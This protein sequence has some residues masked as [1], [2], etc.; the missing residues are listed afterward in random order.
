MSG[1]S[2]L[3]PARD[4]EATIAEAVASCLAQTLPADEVLVVDDH[5]TD[6]TA[7]V[8]AAAGARVIPS[9]GRGLVAALDT[10]LRAAEGTW[11]ARMDADD[12]ADPRRLELQ[13][14]LLQQR[15][16]VDGGVRFFRDDG[17]VP[18][19]MRRYERFVNTV[20]VD[21]ELLVE[22]F[23]VH[24]AA[25]FHRHAVVEAGGYRDGPFPEDYELW[26]R[27]H[28][29]GWTFHKV[30]EL[31]V[32][33]RDRPDRATRTDPRYRVDAFDRARQ[34]W[35]A[36]GPLSRPRRVALW[37][38]GKAGKRWLRWLLAQGHAVPAVVDIADRRE[39]GGLPVVRP[40]TLPDLDVELALVAVGALGAR[41]TIRSALA[42][43]RPGWTEGRD[44]WALR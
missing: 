3:V 38:G 31:L 35:L 37:G 5:S 40:T 1:V 33:M 8:A 26:L 29:G 24:P 17:E 18:P 9:E 21:R 36:A 30:P 25:T 16:V 28:A 27:L 22:S 15:T 39:V 4:A 34:G 7:Q 13:A 41:A 6:A 32:S 12:V 10:G 23:V 44:W 43:L 42:E 2:F 20:D 11:I 19:G 14:P